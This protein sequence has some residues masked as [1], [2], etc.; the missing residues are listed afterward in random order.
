M[1]SLYLAAIEDHSNDG[2]FIDIYKTYENLVFKIALD[3]VGD[4]YYA[5]EAAQ[6]AFFSIA[7]N[8]TLVPT[9]N[10]V[11]TRAYICAVAKNAALTI[12]RKQSRMPKVVSIDELFSLADDTDVDE[13]ICDKETRDI[14]LRTIL[15]LDEPYK[16]T[17]QLRYV[18]EL[19]AKEIAKL[20]GISLNTVKSRLSR[21]MKILEEKLGEVSGV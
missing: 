8:I 16:R 6:D 14:L 13:E 17:L 1:L 7:K 4:F 19:S 12:C 20:D 21:G 5:E 10:E 9:D 3:I 2:I 18:A 15:A 11:R